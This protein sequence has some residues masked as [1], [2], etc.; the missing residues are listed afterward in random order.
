MRNPAAGG[1]LA[2]LLAGCERT[3]PAEEPPAQTVFPAWTNRQRLP[4]SSHLR[5]VRFLSA[6]VGY[7]AG[8]DTSIFRTSDGGATWTQLEHSPLSR[9]GDV[10]A[11]DV[12]A[13]G[14]AVQVGLAGR[15]LSGGGRWW[16]SGDGINFRTPDADSTGFEAMTAVALVAAGTAWYL[17]QNG[18]L[19]RVT[20][21]S[22]TTLHV[23]APGPWRAMAF[24]GAVGYVAGDGGAIRRTA[25][26]GATWSPL[27]TPVSAALRDLCLV[28]DTT[29]Y[30]CG[31]G[32][33]MLKTVDGIS[34]SEVSVGT[35]V[36]LRG[37]HFVDAGTGWVVGDGGFIRRTLDGGMNWSAPAAVPTSLD[38]HDVGFVD[39]VT[40][41]A[42][43]D[44]GTVLKTTDGGLRW[45]EISRG[46]LAR[47]NAVDFSSDGR[48]GMAVGENGAVFRT[49]DGGATWEPSPSGVTADLLGVAVPDAGSGNVAY[50]CGTGGTLLK[51]DDFGRTWTPMN[52]GV[53]ATLRGICFP[54]S[55]TFGYCVGDGSTILHTSTG[56]SW[57]AQ[58]SP[59]AADFHAVDAPYPGSIAYAGGT[60][61]VVIRTEDMGTWWGDRSIGVSTTVRS[62][63]AP[64]GAAVFAAGADGKVYRSLMSGQPGTWQALSLPAAPE[65]LSFPGLTSGWSADGG[66]FFT[67]DSGASWN[68]SFEHTRWTLRAIWAGAGGAGCAV[69]DR[70]T[71]LV[72]RT[73]G[74]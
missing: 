31:D 40:G 38:L 59:V 25:D 65:G 20:P 74:R 13:E 61:G 11:M 27:S 45:T 12:F 26:H 73:G 49:L 32:G 29:G 46:A 15:D 1:L 66:I 17:A 36:T 16:T 67:E 21:T 55:E 64:T 44:F 42:V 4:T 30:A 3:L 72:T 57:V 5:A 35:A 52:S 58:T 39:P 28:S 51:T 9:G 18:A 6:A 8:E 2:L 43:G 19:R 68:R 24:R 48:R 69:G 22:E 23:G 10:A 71:I 14:S 63:Q 54:A 56:T 62:L 70:G 60:G 34:W 37:V 53:S 7:V 50:A 47:L 33:T 41:Y